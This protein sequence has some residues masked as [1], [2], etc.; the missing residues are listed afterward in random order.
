MT[1]D[2]PSAALDLLVVGGLTVDRFADGTAA[3]GG[4][5]LH[6]A[7]AAASRGL[8]VGVVTA[9]GPEPEAQ[10]GLAELR[11]LCVQVEATRYGATTTFRHRETQDGRHLWLERVGGAAVLGAHAADRIVTGAVL[12]GPVADEID[13]GLIQVGAGAWRRGAI[14]QGWLRRP[15]EGAEVEH[16]ALSSVGSELTEALGRFDVLVASREDLAAEADT[17]DQQLTALRK[18][19]GP[20]P[21][22]VVTDGSNGLWLDLVDERVHLGAPWIVDTA[23]TVGSGDILAAFLVAGAD[24]PSSGWPARAE[25]AMRVVAEV[26]EER[27]L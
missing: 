1:A 27:R 25:E 4:S 24:D 14:L 13:V 2:T 23:A 5:V 15:A 8:R 11:R 12:Y 9:A 6:I 21:A 18:A 22:L 3:P 26:L 20:A 16:L 19:I 10:A 17:P 7:R